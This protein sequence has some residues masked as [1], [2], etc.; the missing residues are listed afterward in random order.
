MEFSQNAKISL[1]DVPKKMLKKDIT[2][3]NANSIFVWTVL[4]YI[5]TKKVL[6]R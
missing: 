5:R 2:A 3:K 1:M 4:K 6:K